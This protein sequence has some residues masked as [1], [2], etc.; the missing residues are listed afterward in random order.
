MYTVYAIYNR[1]HDKLYIGQTKNLKERLE[2]HKKGEFKKSYT[3]R[4]N[5]DWELIH[6]EK[7]PTRTD[8]L[9]REKQLKSYRGRE[10]LKNNIP[11]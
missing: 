2:M 7:V 4:F 1:K 9:R 3:K 5:G 6:V 8:A 11:R 10:F